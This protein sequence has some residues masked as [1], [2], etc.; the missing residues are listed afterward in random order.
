MGDQMR[1]IRKAKMGLAAVAAG[2]AGLAVLAGAPR[3]DPVEHGGAGDRDR[4][5]R[6]LR[7]RLRAGTFRHYRVLVT[8]WRV[9]PL[10]RSLDHFTR[11]T[12]IYT[13]KGPVVNG[14]PVRARTWHV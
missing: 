6:R 5:D 8:L 13:H 9:K 7:A 14:R 12:T 2:A 10:T 4:V 1:V 11:L 3:L